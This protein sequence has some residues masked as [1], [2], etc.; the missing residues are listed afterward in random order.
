MVSARGKMW[1][2]PQWLYV[3]ML[4]SLP[5]NCTAAE[6]RTESIKD[7]VDTCPCHLH[8]PV[9]QVQMKAS[10]TQTCWLKWEAFTT[11]QESPDADGEPREGHASGQRKSRNKSMVSGDCAIRADSS[12]CPNTWYLQSGYYALSCCNLSKIICSIRE[13]SRLYFKPA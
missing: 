11:L 6:D 13:K 12:C 8:L 1:L 10:T 4:R 3:T 7:A 5:G 9:V 2:I